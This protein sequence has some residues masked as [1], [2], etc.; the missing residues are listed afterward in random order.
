MPGVGMSAAGPSMSSPVVESKSQKR[1]RQKRVLEQRGKGLFSD[2]PNADHD[3]A[4][5]ARY[6][7]KLK[8][9]MKVA[10]KVGKEPPAFVEDK[11]Q[12]EQGNYLLKSSRV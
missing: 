4:F 10:A 7:K 11:M 9:N 8:Q 6:E 2:S 3:D 5:K 12:P 1:A